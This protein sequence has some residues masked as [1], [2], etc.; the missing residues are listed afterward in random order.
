MLNLRYNLVMDKKIDIIS[1]ADDVASLSVRSILEFWGIKVNIHYVAKSQDLVD[2]FKKDSLSQNLL[3]M[4]HGVEEGIHLPELDPAVVKTQPYDKILTSDN[5]GEFLKLNGQIA[6]STGCKTG[7]K[8][9]ADTFLS[10]GAK[11]YIAPGSYPEGTASLFF[12][13]NFYYF[14][15]VKKL[16]IKEAYTKSKLI[17]NETEMFELFRR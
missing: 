1:I 11:E 12:T 16:P 2:I 17:D 10:K 4:C 5:L 8:A 9:F 14:L 3:L 6:V 7:T 13:V 15:L